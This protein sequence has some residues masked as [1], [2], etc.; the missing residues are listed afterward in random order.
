MKDI[1]I[2]FKARDYQGAIVEERLSHKIIAH[3]EGFFPELE[4]NSIALISCPEY[5]NGSGPAKN[6][7]ESAYFDAF[8]ALN[9]GEGW[10]FN[11]YDLGTIMPG[12]EIKDTYFALSQVVAELVKNNILP[13][14]LGGTQDL[15]FALYQAYQHLEQ[16]VNLTN[17]DYAF[18]LGDPEETIASN[19][20]ISQIMMHRPCYLFNVSTIGIQAPYVKKS[21]MDLFEK[22]YF[23]V[24]RLGE[25]NA[26]FKVAEPLLRNSDILS[27]DLNSIR[28]SDYEN[29]AGM[30]NGFYAN[31]VCQVAKYAGI[32][33]KLAVFGI[34][35]V[36]PNDRNLKN[37]TL[38]AEI[39]WYFIDGFAQRKGDFPIGTKRE[40]TKFNVHLEGY[41]NDLV[42]YKSPK[43]N[44]WWMEVPFPSKNGVKYERH[45]LVPCNFEDYQAAMQNEMP[46]LWWKTYQKLV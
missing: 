13:V 27:L 38:I 39:I 28:F 17:V 19:G 29:E 21:E 34:F 24:C 15:T 26:D 25:F 37:N 2:Y 5:R 41:D 31:Q 42:F 16:M 6:A 4:K 1:S 12:N 46:N 23:D 36:Q 44:R 14:V 11:I 22:L 8:A 30:P 7:G 20:Y 45:H 9:T 18:D 33:D 43:S 3:T 35:N 32:S 10:N 40:Y